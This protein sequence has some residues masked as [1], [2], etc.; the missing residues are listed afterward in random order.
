[1]SNPLVDFRIPENLQQRLGKTH[2]DTRREDVINDAGTMLNIYPG[3]FTYKT[4]PTLEVQITLG[5]DYPD[6]IARRTWMRMVGSLEGYQPMMANEWEIAEHLKHSWKPDSSGR[7]TF[8]GDSTS[9]LVLMWR[10][11]DK[12][13]TSRKRELSASD[14]VQKTAEQ[15]AA[16]LSE[17]LG[18]RAEV[19]A[20]FGDE[21]APTVRRPT[22]KKGR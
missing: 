15:V 5:E 10:P 19:V 21:N 7:L 18:G 2:F 11:A 4:D 16:E 6:L 14:R 22:F 13:E 1:M 12:W 3:E 20:S 8:N 17:R 9:T